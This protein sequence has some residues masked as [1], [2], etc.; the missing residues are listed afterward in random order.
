MRDPA[1]TCLSQGTTLTGQVN[2][3]CMDGLVSVHEDAPFQAVGRLGRSVHAKLVWS[4]QVAVHARPCL[5]PSMPA[6]P[7]M[8]DELDNINSMGRRR[9]D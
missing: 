3:G 5:C 6:R 7:P 4:W 2:R 1:G 9:Q 8:A